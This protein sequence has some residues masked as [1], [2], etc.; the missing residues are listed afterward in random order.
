VAG[1]DAAGRAGQVMR[2]STNLIKTVAE[3]AAGLRDGMEVHGAD[4]PTPDGT[5]IRDYIHVTD[6]ADAHVA[7]LT[8]LLAGGNSAVFNCGYGRGFSVREVLA[9]ADAAAGRPL[10][11][12]MGPRRPGDPPALVADTARIRA[13]LRWQ[14]QWDDLAAMVGSAIAW[15]KRWSAS[16]SME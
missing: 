11:R 1:A 15:E 3:V 6:V 12:R 13:V 10:P 5:C 8:H 7:A 9:A 2:N 16:K 14:P 4:Y